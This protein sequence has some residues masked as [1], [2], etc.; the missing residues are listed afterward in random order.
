MSEATKE[1]S[2]DRF[3]RHLDECRQ[4]R[5]HPFELC[6]HG[7]RLL[8]ATDNGE[9]MMDATRDVVAKNEEPS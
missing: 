5:D 9:L 4:C 8:M 7:M 6:P 3:H 2:I 1:R